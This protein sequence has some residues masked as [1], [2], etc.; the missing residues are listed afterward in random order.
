MSC[1]CFQWR[2]HQLCTISTRTAENCAASVC[3]YSC[4]PQA[5]ASWCTCVC[6]IAS[7]LLMIS[8]KALHSPSTLS[9]CNQFVG[10]WNRF[11]SSIFCPLWNTSTLDSHC[12]SS[13]LSPCMS[14][15]NWTASDVVAASTEW[16]SRSVRDWEGKKMEW[17]SAVKVRGE[18][19]RELR[20][21]WRQQCRSPA[22]S[23]P[24]D[25]QTYQQSPCASSHTWGL[26]WTGPEVRR[27]R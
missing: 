3:A 17:T 2:W 13:L 26:P 9:T 19:E 20:V 18:W 8:L 4:L 27:D 16:F 15:M 10:N 5:P 1:D 14:V 11:R 25:C 6:M 21:P 7:F 24:V 12:F 23:V 22:C